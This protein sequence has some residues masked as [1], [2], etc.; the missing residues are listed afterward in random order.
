MAERRFSIGLGLRAQS[1]FYNQAQ[2]VTLRQ[3]GYALASLRLGWRIN[4][5]LTAALQVDN[6][7]DLRY[8]QS[9][10]GTGWNNRYG[11]PRS[12]TLSLRAEF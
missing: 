1:D 9:L 10:S 6:L 8:Y 5:Q 4:R 2:G 7:T 3:G 12:A 11:E